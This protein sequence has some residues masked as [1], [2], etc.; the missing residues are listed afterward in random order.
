MFIFHKNSL[1]RMAIR[2]VLCPFY[3]SVYLIGKC[4]RHCR[5]KWKE[6]GSSGQ[7]WIYPVQDSQGQRQAVPTLAR[8]CSSDRSTSWTKLIFS[9]CVRLKISILKSKCSEEMWLVENESKIYLWDCGAKESIIICVHVKFSH[10]R[11]YNQSCRKSPKK[12]W[13]CIQEAECSWKVLVKSIR[14]CFYC[15]CLWVCFSTGEG[16]D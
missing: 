4:H 12:A 8:V 14:L 16:L 11:Q 10:W 13:P 6:S 3:K 5:E 9:W 15:P 1:I 2:H 7:L